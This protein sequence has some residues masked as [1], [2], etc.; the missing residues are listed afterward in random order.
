MAKMTKTTKLGDPTTLVMCDVMG[1][2]RSSLRSPGEK[3]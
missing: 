2:V 1:N 3:P